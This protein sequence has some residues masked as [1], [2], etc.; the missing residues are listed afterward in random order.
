MHDLGLAE[1]RL[2]RVGGVAQ[3]APDHR[4]V[5]AV[6]AGP[7]RDALAGQP[8][9]QVRDG[10]PV[11]GV[12]AEH[13][14]DQ[15]RLVLDDLVAGPGF[16]GLAEVPMAVPGRHPVA[17]G[18]QPGVSRE[19]GP[20]AG[21]LRAAGGRANARRRAQPVGRAAARAG[22]VPPTTG[23]RLGRCSRYRLR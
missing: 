23:R 3:H 19:P 16:R 5:P 2:A 8:A 20:D 10:G 12:A 22:I 11:V 1:D 14:G 9:G 6:L 7:G 13:L 17:A 18:H 4:P 21:H 15:R